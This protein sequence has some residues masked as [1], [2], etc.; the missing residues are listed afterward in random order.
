MIIL[1]IFAPVKS[2][3]MRKDES[4]INLYRIIVHAVTASAFSSENR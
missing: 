3:Y 4:K 1:C 2:V